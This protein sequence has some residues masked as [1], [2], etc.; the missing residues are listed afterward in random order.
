MSNWERL[1]IHLIESDRWDG[2]SL[3]TA[4]VQEARNQGIAGAT[5]FRGIE[6]YGICQHKRIHTAKI[7]ELADLPIVVIIIDTQEAIARFL[8]LVKEMVKEGLVVQ[9]ALNVVNHAPF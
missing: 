8:P 5:V 9:E 6:G 2:K 4:L 1:T 3:Y 7:L